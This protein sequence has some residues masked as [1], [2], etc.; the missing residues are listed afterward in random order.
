[1]PTILNGKAAR[2]NKVKTIFSV[3]RTEL[4]LIIIMPAAMHWGILCMLISLYK[5]RSLNY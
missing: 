3:L 1:M 5:K 2:T 4:R